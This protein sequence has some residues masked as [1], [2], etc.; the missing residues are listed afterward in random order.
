[1]STQQPVFE[2]E[3]HPKVDVTELK[4]APTT[5][6]EVQPDGSMEMFERL[7]RDP[8]VSVEK[9]AG[10]MA[11]W[12]RAQ[13]KKAEMAYNA[14]MTAAQKEMRPIAAD[15]WNPQTR[16]RYASY[17]ALDTALRPIYT[18]HGFGLSFDTADTD[19]PDTV[20][21]LCKVT[22]AGGHAE[23]K[24]LDM[25]ADGKGAK[26]GDVMTKTHATASALSYG[27]RYLTKMIWNI[28]VGDSDDDGNRAGKTPAA[29]PEAPPKF[30]DWW[31]DM[32]SVADN[33]L[34]AL[35]QAW[36]DSQIEC[37]RYVSR[38]LSKDWEVLKAKAA[39]VQP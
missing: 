15:A 17:E 39:K 31:T 18:D 26:G 20:R 29:K 38:N 2:M 28:A 21:V 10:M 1:M 4:S 3:M 9:I 24:H 19:K 8:N 22:H 37:R 6:I 27:M 14:A 32:Q 11:L 25:P 36:K 35:Q 30:D 5:A 23:V 33:G 7:A 13:A 34:Q 12:E 16:S